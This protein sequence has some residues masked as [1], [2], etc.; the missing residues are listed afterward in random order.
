MHCSGLDSFRKMD[1]IEVILSTY[2]DDDVSLDFRRCIFPIFP[3]DSQALR[4]E[5]KDREQ[6]T[7]D[8]IMQMKNDHLAVVKII[9]DSLLDSG[10]KI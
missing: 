6:M 1:E 2:F 3:L 9:C 8:D 4:P 5:W 7:S 10:L